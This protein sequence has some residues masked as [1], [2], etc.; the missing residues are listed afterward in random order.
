MKNK[1]RSKLSSVTAIGLSLLMGCASAKYL[2]SHSRSY[3]P[4][5]HAEVYY[6]DKPDRPYI[7]MGVINV[8]AQ[9]ETE[10]LEE[11][12]KKAMEIGADGVIVTSTD[13][14]LRNSSHSWFFLVPTIRATGVAIKFQDT[15]TE[16]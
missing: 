15:P 16:K 12:K 11:F 10:A 4:T 6:S 3:P 7:E 14:R 13:N 9:S 1:S 8:K 2:P 5:K